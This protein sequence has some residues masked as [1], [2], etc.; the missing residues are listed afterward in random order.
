MA[1]GAVGEVPCALG[2]LSGVQAQVAVAQGAEPA[3]PFTPITR[4]R[5][6]AVLELGG[7]PA[8]LALRAHLKAHAEDSQQ[9]ANLLFVALR[10]P[11]AAGYAVR[12]IVGVDAQSG[13]VQLP[14]AVEPGDELAFA[15]RNT[16]AAVRDLKRVLAEVQAPGQVRAA[17]YFNC[18]GRG[19]SLHLEPDADL[20]AIRAALPG[21]PLLGM[22]ASFELGP[23][24]G[25]CR[26]L[27]YSGV[28]VTLR[29]V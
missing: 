2:E 20:H 24:D 25:A 15:W 16:V 23:V 17:L 21:V 27:M 8:A 9:L 6:C 26:L 22:S 29:D 1:G 12:P 5:R 28:L 7:Q 18:A 3:G 14:D 4:S 10:Q 13:A 19:R 11:G